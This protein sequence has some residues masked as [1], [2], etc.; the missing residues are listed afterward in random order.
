MLA[1]TRGY[2]EQVAFLMVENWNTLVL[3]HT[4]YCTVDHT[5]IRGPK[6]KGIYHG[7]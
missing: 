6:Y 1:T 2:C 5:S 4:S 7:K 3:L